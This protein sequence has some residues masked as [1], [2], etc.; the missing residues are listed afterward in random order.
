MSAMTKTIDSFRT[1]LK[2]TLYAVALAGMA[3]VISIHESGT[4][5]CSVMRKPMAMRCE[6]ILTFSL[7]SMMPLALRSQQTEANS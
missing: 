2:C 1:E 5:A 4:A 3:F 7:K 6:S